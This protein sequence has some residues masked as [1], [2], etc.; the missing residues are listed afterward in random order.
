MGCMG[1]VTNRFEVLEAERHAGVLRDALVFVI[2]R[3]ASTSM[4]LLL[5]VSHA[6]RK[7]QAD[8]PDGN[9]FA[10][11]IKYIQLSVHVFA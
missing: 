9:I 11:P 3:T 5:G 7:I 8:R 4:T 1:H 2:S 6:A 10:K